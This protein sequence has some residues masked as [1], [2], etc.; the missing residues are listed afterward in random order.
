MSDIELN[1]ALAKFYLEART[2]KGEQYSRSALLGFRN[3]IER[4]LNNNSRV[5]KIS[6]K[7]FFQNAKLRINRRE[8]KENVKHKPIIEAADLA[9]VQSSEFTSMN[10][11][12]GLQRRVCF[13]I[14]LYWCR[15]GREGQRELTRSSFEFLKDGE[16]REFVMMTHDEATKNHPGGETDKQS[17]ER[18]TRLYSTGKP[19]D[20]FASV[21]QYV[22][23]LNPLCNAFFQRPRPRIRSEDPVWYEN[24][25]LGVNSLGN[26][27]KSI[28]TGC[29][30]SKI[31]TNHSVRATAISLWSDADIPDR[32]IT[33]ASGHSN[34]QS[35][36]HYSS[37]PSA[38]QLRKFSD[39]ISNALAGG[40][41][42]TV[43]TS[44]T[45][46]LISS[47]K[48]VLAPVTSTTTNQIAVDA[49][50]SMNAFPSGF[51][52]SCS[53]GNVHVYLGSKPNQGEK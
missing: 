6:K 35:L 31:C 20:A 38:P 9:R 3:S 18:E 34:E 5:V 37:V 29:N 25:P 33:F 49:S 30:L 11:P 12:A 41:V 24:K 23:K 19:D 53:I 14:S 51:F 48:R 39:T 4:H 27:M 1:E 2:S 42:S 26:M 36:A 28:S 43:Q 22:S 16:G 21:K 40:T 15:R 44:S 52:S 45:T 47:P 7:P 8:G 46:A 13:F 32:H 50:L 17:S 10:T